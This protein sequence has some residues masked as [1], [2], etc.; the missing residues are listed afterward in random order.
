[1]RIARRLLIF[2][3]T[4]AAIAAALVLGLTAAPAA[5]SPVLRQAP[6]NPAFKL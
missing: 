6:Q 3:T 4:M 1:M 2:C 5:A